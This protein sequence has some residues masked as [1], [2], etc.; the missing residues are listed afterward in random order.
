MAWTIYG[1][2]KMRMLI[3]VKIVKWYF[4]STV[5]NHSEIARGSIFRLSSKC[6]GED[7]FHLVSG[8]AWLGPYISNRSS[9][10]W[11]AENEAI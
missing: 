7:Q 4:S 6:V 9:V 3:V 8:T 2:F 5:C 1:W 11:A 10:V